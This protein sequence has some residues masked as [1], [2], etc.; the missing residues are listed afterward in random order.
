MF[1]LWNMSKLW[2]S[3]VFPTASETALLVFCIAPRPGSSGAIAICLVSFTTCRAWLPW[4][5][6][7]LAAWLHGYEKIGRIRQ[8]WLTRCLGNRASERAQWKNDAGALLSGQP[9]SSSSWHGPSE[10]STKQSITAS[11]QPGHRGPGCLMR[12][13]LPWAVNQSCPK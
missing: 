4:Y 11:G 8:A 6:K 13:R 5:K 7:R 12:A 2:V 1:L 10:T 3:C 9:I